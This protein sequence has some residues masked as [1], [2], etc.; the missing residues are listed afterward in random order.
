MRGTWLTAL[1]LTTSDI[2]YRVWQGCV[3]SNRK[4]KIKIDARP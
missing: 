3:V 4:V 1:W 2:N